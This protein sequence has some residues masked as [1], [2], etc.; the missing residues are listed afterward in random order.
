VPVLYIGRMV[1]KAGRTRTD[2]IV[3]VAVPDV[4]G[5]G[6]SSNFMARQHTGPDTTKL[7]GRP[8]A[9]RWDAGDPLDKGPGIQTYQLPEKGRTSL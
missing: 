5:T 6:I 3:V 9:C 8:T 2:K 4:G 1:R 7:L